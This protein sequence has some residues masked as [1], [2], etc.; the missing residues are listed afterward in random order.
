MLTLKS[1]NFEQRQFQN[2]HL[3]QSRLGQAEWII[4]R[5]ATCDLVLTSPEVSRVHGRIVYIDNAYHFMDAGSVS[6]S[7]LN[8]ESVPVNEVRQLRAGDLL[9]LGETFLHIEELTIPSASAPDRA[10]QPP[11]VLPETAWTN[12]DLL[13]RCSR[14]IDETPDVKTFCLTAEPPVLFAYKPGQFVN[15]ELEIDGKTV[16]RSYSISSSPTRPYHLSLTVKRVPSPPDQP[17]S[18]AGLVSNWLHDHLQVGDHI[19]LLGGPLGHFTFLPNLPSKLLLI[20]AGSGITPMM[21]MSRWVQ[22]TLADCDV[23]FLHCARTPN[24]IV[25][26]TELEAIAAQMPNFHLAITLTQSSKHGWM[27]LTGRISQSMLQLVV[28]D[29]LDRAVFVCGPEGF[30]QGIRALMETL[31]FPMQ[32]YKEESFGSKKSKPA[33]SQPELARPQPEPTRSQPELVRSQPQLATIADLDAPLT[34]AQNGNGKGQHLETLLKDLPPPVKSPRGTA[35]PAI[36]FISSD[37]TV[38]TDANSSILEVAEQ[39]GIQIR[40]GCRAG[41]CGVCKV[42]V[43]K[44]Q[45]RYDAQPPALT[46]AD[47]QAGYALSCVAYPVNQLAIEA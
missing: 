23:V 47:Q 45:V 9:Q 26:R 6:G 29:L 36:H 35:T 2:H 17:N 39:E 20:S 5:S 15:L 34:V 42:R 27:G 25:F 3:K 38:P 44:G 22:D 21:S 16:I 43:H 12:E 46:A 18:P 31:Q 32:N 10:S 14:I 19:K 28:P 8:G 41:A 33:R 30:M 13:C 1:V 4:G 7:L 11:L 24:D 40:S 37:R